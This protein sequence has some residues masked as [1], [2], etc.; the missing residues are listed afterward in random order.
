M[1]RPESSVACSEVVPALDLAQLRAI[2]ERCATDVRAGVHRVE[3]DR[4]RRW[5][6][7]IHCDDQVDV[8]LISWTR[9]QDLEL[10]DHG[11]SA[12]AFNVVE[13]CLTESVWSGTAERGRLVDH[14]REAGDVVV[15]GSHDVH[16]VR[17]TAVASAV[18]V[19]AYSP[20]LRRMGFYDVA[21]DRLVRRAEAWTDVPHTASDA[22]LAA[23]L[24]IVAGPT[25]VQQ[26]V[27][28]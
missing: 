27:G 24:P 9:T 12:G 19:H 5:R 8:W 17:N 21:G 28:G 11:D 2:V 1:L 22:R 3:F 15:F 10:H 6:V 18:S 13:G 16:D 25:L 4:D 20:P 7:R 14:A 26:V 23:G